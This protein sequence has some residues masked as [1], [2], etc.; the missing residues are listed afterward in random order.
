M[1]CYHQLKVTSGLRVTRLEPGRL[2]AL[3]CVSRTLAE[4]EG[5]YAITEQLASWFLAHNSQVLGSFDDGERR[6][7]PPSPQPP[8]PCNAASS[9]PPAR[10]S[11]AATRSSSASTAGPTHPFCHK[12]TS[13]PPKSP[14]GA[15]ADS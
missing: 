6:S 13:P 12:P 11:T 9:A 1:A 10:S 5:N 15:A 7:P 3:R 4:G 2:K 14:G 8:T